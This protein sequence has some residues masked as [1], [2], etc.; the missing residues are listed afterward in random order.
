M[1]IA[2]NFELVTL[3]HTI[4]W[5]NSGRIYPSHLIFAHLI[6]LWTKINVNGVEGIEGW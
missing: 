5:R 6:F 1:V 2:S 3:H 4:N